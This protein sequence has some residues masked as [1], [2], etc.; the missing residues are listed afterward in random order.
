[1]KTQI[2]IK[3]FKDEKQVSE[4]TLKEIQR[5]GWS[6]SKFIEIQE[7]QGRMCVLV[8]MPKP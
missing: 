7:I 2:I 4:I 1:M 6:L 3:I 8:D 5:K